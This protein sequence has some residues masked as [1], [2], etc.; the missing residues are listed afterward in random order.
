MNIL[1]ASVSDQ[2][3]SSIDPLRRR[4][5]IKVRDIHRVIEFYEQVDAVVLDF[6]DKLIDWYQVLSEL[7]RKNGSKSVVF[8]STPDDK[9]CIR[10]SSVHSFASDHQGVFRSLVL[11]NKDVPKS[12]ECLS[13]KK[14]RK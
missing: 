9:I 13:C 10:H 14:R 12:K 1:V 11:I 3:L 2:F 6:D 7:N 8:S 4:W 5:S